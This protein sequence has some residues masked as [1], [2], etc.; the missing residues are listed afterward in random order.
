M[1][2]IKNVAFVMLFANL[3]F[4]AFVLGQGGTPTAASPEEFCSKDARSEIQIF[5]KDL[6]RF[7]K[8]V[9][10]ENS[11]GTPL[12]AKNFANDLN[13]LDL[14]DPDAR[15]KFITAL[16][17]RLAAS[18]FVSKAAAAGAMGDASAQRLDRQLGPGH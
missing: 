3:A 17:P 14:H 11:K 16:A 7:Q 15:V 13:H 8:H 9:N 5:C 4:P 12:A 2:V 10:N 1:T 18:S 6:D